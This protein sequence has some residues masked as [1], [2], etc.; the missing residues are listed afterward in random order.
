MKLVLIESPYRATTDWEL[1][2]NLA[3]LRALLLDCTYRG[4]S[5]V[6][7]HGLLTQVLDDRVGEER[8]LGMTCHIAWANAA[9]YVVVAVDGGITKGM[10]DGW[11]AHRGRGCRVEQRSLPGWVDAWNVDEAASRAVV[12]AICERDG[13]NYLAPQWL[14]HVEHS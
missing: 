9:D 12:E 10:R 6:A 13:R 8:K 14:P 2:R 11:R 7:M 5:P 3:Y 1:A 4:E